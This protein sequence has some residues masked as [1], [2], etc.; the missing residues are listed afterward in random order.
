MTPRW[1]LFFKAWM[2]AIEKKALKVRVL[3]SMGPQIGYKKIFKTADT[4][5][6]T[7]RCIQGIPRFPATLK[8]KRATR[9]SKPKNGG[10]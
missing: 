3:F 10:L 1:S 8:I 2:A 5:M 4:N 7:A 9:V 6:A